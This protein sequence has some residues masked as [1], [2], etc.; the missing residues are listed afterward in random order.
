MKTIFADNV[1]E[2]WDLGILLM[3]NCRRQISPRGIPTREHNMPVATRYRYPKQRVLF[4]PGRDANPFFHLM[5]ALWMMAG[6]GDVS[7]IEQF[8]SNITQFSDD[9]KAFHGA[10]GPRL[11]EG[12]ENNQLRRVVHLLKQEPDTRRAVLQIWDWPEDLGRGSNDIPCNTHAYLKLRDNRLHITVCCRSNDMVWGAYGV[13]AV[14]FSILQEYI[15]AQL[16]VEVG[17]YTQVSDS[18]HVYDDNE[19]W[20]R[21]RKRG[22]LWT[23]PYKD[24]SVGTYPLV[25]D[26]ITWDYDLRNFVEEKPFLHQSYDNPFFPNVAGRVRDAYI[27]H[28]EG[29]STG[30][31]T[32]ADMIDAPDWRRACCE[33]LERRRNK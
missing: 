23:D 22:P 7:W 32:C 24:D 13:N 26:P 21:V 29:D 20:Q 30:A 9:G 5:E 25:E 4:D 19:A 12:G 3:R 33:W 31:F 16:E 18:F 27:F 10:Y 11:T 28:K 17:I 14:Q 1:N 6:R 2:A 15:A 8:N